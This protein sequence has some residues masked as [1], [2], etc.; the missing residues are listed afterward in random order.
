MLGAFIETRDAGV[1]LVAPQTMGVAVVPRNTG[2]TTEGGRGGRRGRRRRLGAGSGVGGVEA[3]GLCRQFGLA[4]SFNVGLGEMRLEI[5]ERPIS[6]VFVAPFVNG[7]REDTGF[8]K[9]GE[10]EAEDG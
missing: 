2:G 10:K 1:V 3:A 6:G 5:C 8:L 7:G 9:D 4:L